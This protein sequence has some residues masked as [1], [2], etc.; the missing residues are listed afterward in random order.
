MSRHCYAS[1]LW[2]ALCALM[3]LAAACV[4]EGQSCAP[5]TVERGG[6]CVPEISGCAP[7]TVQTE[8][9]R[10]EP[11]CGEHEVLDGA[12]NCVPRCA[13]GT[14][15][16][17]DG[18]CEPVC[19]EGEFWG[20]E[21]CEPV[22]EC[23]ADTVF[24]PATGT[25]VPDEGACGEGAHLQD[26]ECVADETLTC[27]PGAKLQGGRCVPDDALPEPDVEESA[28]DT[29]AEFTPPADG[30]SLTLGGTVDF[31]A[32]PNNSGG[33]LA[34]WDGFAFHA[35]AGTWLRVR[36]MSEAAAQP[37]FE[38]VSAETG[39]NRLPLYTRYGVEF[40]SGLVDREV[41]LPR[42]GDYVLS[43]TEREHLLNRVLS[44]L[45]TY[46]RGGDA[47]TYHVTLDNLGTPAPTAVDA[48]PD[49]RSGD[50]SD[51]KLRFYEVSGLA[52]GD[53]IGASSSGLPDELVGSDQFPA[54]MVF[55][56]DGQL[57]RDVVS[58]GQ[59]D[60]AELLFLA[61]GSEAH[62]VVQGVFLVLGPRRD[63]SLDLWAVSATDCLAG[64]CAA[65][66]LAE[67][68][69]ALLRWD[70]T[71]GQF[72]IA[73]VY[74]PP[75]VYEAVRVVGLDGD[76]E[77]V[78]PEHVAS[79]YGPGMAQFYAE[80]D[81]AAYLWLRGWDG[82]AV[83]EC[84]IDA[85]II[86]TAPLEEGQTHSG[87]PVYEFPDFTL[88][89]AGVAH[90]K[91]LGDEV[92]FFQRFETHLGG[93]GGAWA[94]PQ[95]VLM[96]PTMEQIGPVIDTRAWNFPDGMISPLFTYFPD[97]RHVLH[98]TWD[99]TSDLTDATYDVQMV[100]KRPTALG[101]VEAG[102]PIEQDLQG[103]GSSLAFYTLDGLQDQYVEITV[104]PSGDDSKLKPDL[105]VFNFGRAEFV[106]ISYEWIEDP[107]SRQMALVERERA[108]ANGEPVSLLYLSPYEG[109]SLIMVQDDPDKEEPEAGFMDLFKIT[110][111]VPPPPD[112]DS[113]DGAEPVVLDAAGAAV[114]HG[115]NA[116]ATDT[117]GVPGCP[118]YPTPGPDVFYRIELA[119]GDI[120]DL[121]LD[122]YEYSVA[123]TLFW[124]CGD[125]AG[126]CLALSESGRP[127]TIQYTVPEL[128]G[129][130]YYI[131]VD[132]HSR[133]GPFTLT[134]TV[135]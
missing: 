100:S 23:G 93:G 19:G 116:A 77:V 4:E 72:F 128:G 71:E 45:D 6:E 105:W 44:G 123:L 135:Q 57:V 96:T 35:E 91:D 27:G 69:E 7:G 119:A 83:T 40:N 61:Q 34:D 8:D 125:P 65:P 51:G 53:I 75:D 112:N 88:N 14:V 32:D 68:E 43:I 108:E 90:A 47:F 60:P 122:D 129:G 110:V 133:G 55:G 131:G 20:H 58:Y 59:H 118:G 64:D 127:R 52:A 134:V 103:P 98:Y 29:A 50:L 9:G 12:G 33:A 130:A 42:T 1:V 85:R 26:G 39:A 124:D 5:G 56:P 70:L 73:G 37:A 67:N 84:T 63:F 79:L 78:A 10:C 17:E 2:V 16:N 113:C 89:P 11:L 74:I 41:Y 95:E 87:L 49:A 18:E 38:L 114:I 82:W 81:T 94:D 97:D 106:W 102:T 117:V 31:P 92:V 104:E 62:L 21:G 80:A 121:S 107:S 76:L 24:D 25:C 126:S 86:D 66:D 111:S 30:E 46:P 28:D 115:S 120:L 132:G 109:R 101:T 54:V 15:R 22:P 3:L 36:V 99:A 13:D 48:L